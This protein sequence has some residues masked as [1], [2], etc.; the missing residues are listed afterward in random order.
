MLFSVII[1]CYNTLPIIKQCIKAVLTTT[2][3]EAEILLVNNHPPYPDVVAYL[4]GYSH[5][6]VKVLDPGKNL[7]HILG[8]Q[9]AEQYA[10]GRYLIRMDDDA[11][12]PNNNWIYAMRQA[13]KHFPDLAFIGLPPQGFSL[14]GVNRVT[15]GDLVIEYHDFVLFTCVMFKRDLWKAHFIMPP[16]GVYGYDDGYA[17]QKAMELGLKKAYLVSHPC[18]HLGRTKEC[19]P[20]Y[21]AW[22]LF[23]AIKRT[24]QDFAAWRK[25]IS[26]LNED[27]EKLMKDFGYPADQIAE[28]KKIIR[29]GKF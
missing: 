1:N 4:K 25:T 16:Q 15:A 12:V 2:D 14:P 9:Y 28:I 13:L 23:Y 24:D 21:G 26:K 22:K 18:L 11:I 27:D 6:R 29:H 17:S 10:S 5:P 3:N 8:T 7:S 19:D 20:L